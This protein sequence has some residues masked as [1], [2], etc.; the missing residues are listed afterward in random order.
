M[1]TWPSSLTSICDSNSSQR[2]RIVSPPLPIS[3]PIWS[4]IDLD[5]LDA[6]R[7][8]AS[9]LARR[10]DH[11]G[12]LAEDEQAAALGLRQRVAQDLEGDAARS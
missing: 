10:G 6:R 3:R 9:S 11:G 4:G 5:R 7:E 2:P 1:S 12:H 8:L